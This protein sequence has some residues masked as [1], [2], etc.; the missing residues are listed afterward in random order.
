MPRK[1]T[2]SREAPHAFAAEVG[3]SL[4]EHIER[5]NARERL[6]P[7][8]PA[9]DPAKRRLIEDVIRGMLSRARKEPESAPAI[10][11]ELEEYAAAFARQSGEGYVGPF[12]LVKNVKD[13]AVGLRGALVNLIRQRAA[14]TADWDYSAFL[15]SAPQ[16]AA[17]RRP[18]DSKMEANRLHSE[19]S[20]GML[21]RH[22]DRCTCSDCEAA[23]R[24]GRPKPT[25]SLQVS[26]DAL[27]QDRLSDPA[28][29]RARAASIT[30]RTTSAGVLTTQVGARGCSL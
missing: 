10:V 16:V 4:D 18:P 21:T 12:R 17:T 27:S 6:A 11:A 7:P 29:F 5:E 30:T 20:L 2:H 8:S 23:L 1:R 19:L 28:N 14:E 24:S 25:C 22:E 15:E 9:F 13:A 3:E 26:V